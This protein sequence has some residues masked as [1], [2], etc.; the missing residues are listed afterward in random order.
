[1]II[2]QQNRRQKELETFVSLFP[3]ASRFEHPAGNTEGVWVSNYYSSDTLPKPV[4]YIL[5]I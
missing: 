5:A 1:M 2:R 4:R 3:Q